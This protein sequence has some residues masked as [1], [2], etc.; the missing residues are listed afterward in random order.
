MKKMSVLKFRLMNDVGMLFKNT[1]KALDL[2][3]KMTYVDIANSNI[4][5]Y[6]F[7]PEEEQNIINFRYTKRSYYNENGEVLEI[8][9]YINSKELT[10]QILYSLLLEIYTS[11][12]ILEVLAS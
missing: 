8:I 4:Q 2:L 5:N 11:T 7:T 1:D 6:R 12:L 10:E 9:A 3:E